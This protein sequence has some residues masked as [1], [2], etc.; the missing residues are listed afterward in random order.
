[1]KIKAISTIVIITCV[2][3]LTGCKPKL[4]P[5]QQ[6]QQA[7][8]QRQQEERWRK[9]E[10][11]A[12]QRAAR[13]AQK[14]TVETAQHHKVANASISY[15]NYNVRIKNADT[16]NWPELNVY[17]NSGLFGPMSGYGIRLPALPIGKSITIPL[18]QFTK[19]NGERFNPAAYRVTELWIGGGDYDYEKF[20]AN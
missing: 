16:N 11:L 3:N 4:T 8:Q 19:D 6:K 15:D 7:E 18:E 17:I 1:M 13:D 14:Q 20:G 9:T 10:E 12:A 5:E 2:L